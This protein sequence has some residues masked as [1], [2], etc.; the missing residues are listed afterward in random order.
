[1]PPSVPSVEARS[2]QTLDCF[3]DAILLREGRGAV[4]ATYVRGT[5]ST[6]AAVSSH[7]VSS[8]LATPMS[9]A[10]PPP[11]A[12]VSAF[13]AA[14]PV[15]VVRTGRATERAQRVRELRALDAQLEAVRA[16][17][18]QLA[19]RVARYASTL[20]W[21]LPAA[22]AIGA[23]CAALSGLAAGRASFEVAI[24]ACLVAGLVVLGVVF[25]RAH[26]ARH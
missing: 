24:G 25:A 20:G 3:T 9:G 6:T 11:F 22:F 17:R 23:S 7:P 2:S 19:D 15:I 26:E 16:E 14:A 8:S 18:S 5:S 12:R 13:P 10:G 1:M 4:G 21:A